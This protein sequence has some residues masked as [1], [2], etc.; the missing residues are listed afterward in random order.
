MPRVR[1]RTSLRTKLL[2]ILLAAVLVPSIVVATMLMR[3]G[4]HV[5]LSLLWLAGFALLFV[6][7][8]KYISLRVTG[9]L[10]RL[11]EG[12]EIIGSGNLDY[13]IDV[14]TGDE[15]ED[16]ADAFNRTAA[17][18]ETSYRELEQEHSRA[19]VAARQADTLYHVSQ[20]LVSTLRL[21]ETL[22]LIARSLADVCDTD[23]VALW[24]VKGNV[25]SPTTSYGLAEEEDKAFKGWEAHLEEAAGLTKQAIATRKPV[26]VTD[27]ATDERVSHR[28]LEQFPVRSILAL[29][30]VIEDD[31]IGYAITFEAGKVREFT[32]YQVSMAKAVAAQA[33]VA[34]RNAQAYERERRIAETLQRSLLPHVPPRFGSFEIADR[35][36]SALSEAEIGG[37][38]YDLVELSPTRMAFVMADISGKGLSAAVHTAMMKYMLRAYSL[39][40]MDGPELI[41]RLNRAVWKYIGEQMFITL[42]YGVLDTETKRLTYVNAG[43]ELPLLYAAE[44]HLCVRLETTG[45][46]LGIFPDYDFGEASIEFMPGDSLLLYT[47]GATDVRRDRVFLGDDGVE[48]I[49]SHAAAGNAHQIVDAVDAGIREY[50]SNELHDDVALMVIKYTVGEVDRASESLI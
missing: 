39:D 16:L 47:D 34:I 33:G 5:H 37:D 27:A 30:L 43:H 14:G 50:A 20:A 4:I 6:L 15:I 49:F 31:V 22:D 21:D 23:K 35:Y 2:I 28:M 36:N 18:L 41:H 8:G 44:R 9:P 17:R 24:L 7:L 38:F 3:N 10:A 25:L 1:H 32:D 42:F 13:R 11:K 26:I 29:P 12:A 46:A 40:D 48:A 45:T 19:V